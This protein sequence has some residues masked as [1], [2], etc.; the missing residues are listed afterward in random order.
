[1]TIWRFDDYIQ[2]TINQVF[3]IEIVKLPNCHDEIFDDA[4]SSSR[5]RTKK[6]RGQAV[7]RTGYGLKS[8]IPT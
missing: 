6:G 1:M 7:V 8:R 4:D 5:G 2:N 3:I